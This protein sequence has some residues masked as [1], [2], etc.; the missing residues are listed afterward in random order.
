MGGRL[1]RN[2]WHLYT[3]PHGVTSQTTASLKTMRISTAF[4]LPPSNITFT[5]LLFSFHLST[6]PSGTNW[7][8]ARNRVMP[9]SLLTFHQQSPSYGLHLF[10]FHYCINCQTHG[11]SCLPSLILGCDVAQFTDIYQTIRRHWPS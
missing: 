7:T 2:C 4:T 3:E 9:R 1:L 10:A 11:F 5:C 8:S 6:Q